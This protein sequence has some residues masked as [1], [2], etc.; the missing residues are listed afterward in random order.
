MRATLLEQVGCF[1]CRVGVA[2][3]IGDILQR[4]V[5]LN[6]PL[7]SL[8]SLREALF[9]KDIGRSPYTSS[10]FRGP[11]L[12]L[13]LFRWTSEQFIRQVVSLAVVDWITAHLL[14]SI[15][16][17][18]TRLQDGDVQGLRIVQQ[19]APLLYL[20]NPCLILSTAAGSTANLATLFVLT[21]L[22]GGLVG[23]TALAGLGLAAATY[24]SAHPLLM[25]V[26]TALL[27]QKHVS[28]QQSKLGGESGCCSS[29]AKFTD[30]AASM[31]SQVA[32]KTEKAANEQQCNLLDDLQPAKQSMQKQKTRV[33]CQL[34]CFFS[35]FMLGLLLLSETQLRHH[36]EHFTVS[37]LGSLGSSQVSKQQSLPLGA[38]KCQHWTQH[39]YGYMLTG[40]DSTPNIGMWWYFFAE[41]FPSWR[42][43]L[44]CL[45]TCAAV[46]PPLLLTIKLHQQ[47]LL[48]FLCQCIVNS[49]LK[50]YPTAADA[51]QFMALLPLFPHLLLQLPSVA[52]TATSLLLLVYLGPTMWYLWM[53]L[54]TGNANFYYAITLLWSAWQ[55][56]LLL[57]LLSVALESSPA[58][59]QQGKHIEKTT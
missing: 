26:P 41:A 10:Y 13:P 53:D 46:I 20:L 9:W 12:L 15:A 23:N 32:H 2:Y 4:R 3:I 44:K 50:P 29:D 6:T 38:S 58:D 56:M 18:V 36:Q 19:A 33:T 37:T 40:P 24:L 51:A 59:G 45:F 31:H 16:D 30:K 54:G 27:L 5:E 28:K 52:F 17:Q 22:Q 25:L 1:A 8:I 35:V 14:S 49:M 43:P 57:Q 11:P 34:L 7:H 48:L 21:A 47:P 42:A 39:V 55:A